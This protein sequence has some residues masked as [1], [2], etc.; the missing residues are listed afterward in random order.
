MI[1]IDRNKK[2]SIGTSG[3]NFD[4]FVTP[5]S[6]SVF[7]GSDLIYY[8]EQRVINISTDPVVLHS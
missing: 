8:L 2:K 3:M 5:S 7:E 4:G 1:K 6:I